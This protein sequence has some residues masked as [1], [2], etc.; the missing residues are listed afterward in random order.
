MKLRL[1]ARW[2]LRLLPLFLALT[3]AAAEPL[4]P[5]TIIGTWLVD[6]R[7]A[8][9][10]ID[11][12]G[13]GNSRRYVG[14]I[15]WIQDDHYHAEDG[16]ALDGK[17]VVDLNNPDPAQRNQPLLGLRLLWDLRYE[18]SHWIGGRIYDSDNGHIFDCTVQLKD[19]DHLR[20]HAYVLHL[21][22]LGGSTI[23][24][25]STVPPTG[26]TAAI[27]SAATSSH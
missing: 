21:P 1:T 9:I 7:D 6:S 14:H 19:A 25:R 2:L 11:G 22:L 17:P 13:D 4:P 12:V 15:A 8:V 23:W 5:D 27:P 16:P 26:T 10:R 24:T 20:L 18:Q 3:A